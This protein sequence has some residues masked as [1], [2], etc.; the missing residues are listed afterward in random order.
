M[1]TKAKRLAK[2]I[3]AKNVKDLLSYRAKAS[4]AAR[5]AI[6]TAIR[7]SVYAKKCIIS[8]Y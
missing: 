7:L 2:H 1:Y 8:S 6:S 4:M 5:P 3:K